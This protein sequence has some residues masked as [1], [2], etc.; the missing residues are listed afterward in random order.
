MHQCPRP[1]IY[2]PHS[3][4]IDNTYIDERKIQPLFTRIA[5]VEASIPLGIVLETF[6]RRAHKQRV[7]YYTHSEPTVGDMYGDT[8]AGLARY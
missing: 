1:E 5:T 8:V 4:P 3:P 6:G 7:E 2:V